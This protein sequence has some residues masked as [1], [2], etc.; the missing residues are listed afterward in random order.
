MHIECSPIHLGG[1]SSH[2]HRIC[3]PLV[4]A[5]ADK[6]G[7]VGGSKKQLNRMIFTPFQPHFSKPLVCDCIQGCTFISVSCPTCRFAGKEVPDPFFKFGRSKNTRLPRCVVP[8]R[9]A[10]RKSRAFSCMS[11]TSSNI[12]PAL[13]WGASRMK[14]FLKGALTGKRLRNTNLKHSVMSY[15]ITTRRDKGTFGLE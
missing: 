2:D 10:P 13:N 5:P 9:K 1:I 12:N 8:L 3:T 7:A 4:A 6:E 11:A 14:I 15:T